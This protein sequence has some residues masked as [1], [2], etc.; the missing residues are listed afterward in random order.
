MNR[1][2]KTIYRLRYLS[3]SCV[4]LLT[5]FFA[6]SIKMELDN[7]ISSWF[8]KDDP[9]SVNYNS[10]RDAFE[11]GRYL[12]V[13]I[14]SAD[15]FSYDILNYIRS[16]TDELEQM[17]R[18]KQIH[19]LSN[20]NK[21]IGTTDGIEINPLLYNLEDADI[22]DLKHQ[23]LTDDLF[24][25]YLISEDSTLSTIIL[26]CDDMNANQ[27]EEV[28]TEV[29][30]IVEKDKPP[31][32]ETFLS[33]GIML[34]H[35]FNKVT[36]QNETTLPVLG[37]IIIIIIVLIIFRSISK[38]AI[39]V[40]IIGMSLCWTLGFHSILGYTFNALS[41]M[42]I[43]LIIILSIS[44]T[45]HII[46]YFDEI[47]K[48]NDREDAFIA[49]ISYIT[50]PCFITSITTSI[51]LLS[52]A[53]SPI[54]SVK[55]FGI[56]AAS[57]VMFAFIIS[58]VIVPV[59]LTMLHSHGKEHHPYWG[60]MLAWIFHLSEKR[61]ALILG[62]T[63]SAFILS[64]L[65]FNWIKIETNELEWFP[66]D[67]S[68]YITSKTL[69]EKLSGIGNM[70]LIIKGRQ[71]MLKQP[72]I[73]KR[74]DAFSQEIGRLTEVK[75]VISL[76]S[77][78]KAVNKALEED[79]EDAYRVPDT[80]ELIAQEILLFSFSESG[81]D[82]LERVS[83]PDYSMGRVNIKVSYGSSEEGRILAE[84]I[85]DMAVETFRDIDDIKITI[86]GSSY[87][88]S[89]LDKYIVESQIRSFT[90]AFG[91]VFGLLFIIL[92]SIRYGLLTILPNILPITLIIG[93]MGWFGIS[94][95]VG[96]VMIASVALGIAVDDTIHY[97][98]RFI[99]ESRKKQSTLH[100]CL[101]KTTIF[102]GRA[103][104]F[105][106]MINIAGFSVVI[107]SGFQPSRD[108]GLLLSLTLLFALVCD[109]F[110][111]P[112]IMTAARRFFEKH[113]AKNPI[114]DGPFAGSGRE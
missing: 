71:D 80:R 18:V 104:V 76:A 14:E 81:L 66:K 16:K 47:R 68:V 92:R 90:L 37:L 63:A 95:N 84:R 8:S 1:L 40:S 17:D 97:I 24:R 87:L 20:A 31:D 94:L 50:I 105:T 56:A 55:H 3:A 107:F 74:I 67:S 13:A 44:N 45:I 7:T 113:P 48:D 98:S 27:M 26:V 58:I 72:L 5:L 23:A 41:G 59:S 106:S 51:G 75:K 111:L 39:V 77:Y 12:I 110:V 33:G 112:S 21:V 2:S 42:I 43:P 93:V 49:T 64:V 4:I 82:E 30:E 53:T 46:E 36:K 9:I 32:T 70:E 69:D 34:N 52:L 102:V 35:E 85:E 62:I 65:G 103:V 86:T 89:M 73:L 22:A 96:T 57:G 6:S 11:G 60:H 100:S 91:L 114:G 79:R 29:E 83:T 61:Y 99:K 88:L 101:R 15:I 108:F 25:D 28:I 54:S 38:I 19:S 10:F 109:L 78:V